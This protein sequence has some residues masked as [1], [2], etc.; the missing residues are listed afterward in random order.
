MYNHKNNSVDL[1][2]LEHSK[3]HGVNI[4]SYDKSGNV[5]DSTHI[6]G[7]KLHDEVYSTKTKK[8]MNAE[9]YHT[10]KKKYLNSLK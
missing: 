3:I 9:E 1:H 4:K 8:F 6:P 10:T 5:T 2:S 7:I